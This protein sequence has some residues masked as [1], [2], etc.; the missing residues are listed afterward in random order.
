MIG[1]KAEKTA[2]IDSIV[3]SDPSAKIF[4]FGS[5]ADD[6]KKGGDIDILSFSETID[7]SEK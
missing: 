1:P 5:K 2:T 4:L 6:T 7:F 3:K